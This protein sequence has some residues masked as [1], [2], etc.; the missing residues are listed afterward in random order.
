MLAFFS[1]ALNDFLVLL[2]CI[3]T[4][5]TTGKQYLSAL[6]GLPTMHM[7]VSVT[8]SHN[9]QKLHLTLVIKCCSW[10]RNQAKNVFERTKQRPKTWI[11]NR[12]AF[13]NYLD[14]FLAIFDHPPTPHRQ[15]YTI[16]LPP[17]R[18]LRRHFDND[19]PLPE[20]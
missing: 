16:G 10:R 20:K 12:G 7:F 4:K 5:K 19:H 1:V 2:L 8:S 18:C 17:T 9:D 15:M 3:M 11:L 13:N 14:R 6:Y